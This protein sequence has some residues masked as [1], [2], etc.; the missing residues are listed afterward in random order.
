MAIGTVFVYDHSQVVSIP[1]EVSFPEHVHVVDVRANGDELVIAPVRTSWHD[2]F[3]ASSRVSGD[4]LPERAS[5][6]QPE[7]TPPQTSEEP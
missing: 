7:R 3:L 6:H 2:F 1:E 4:F 5:Q